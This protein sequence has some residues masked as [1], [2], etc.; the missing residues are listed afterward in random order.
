M[1]TSDV[2]GAID[3]AAVPYLPYERPHTQITISRILPSPIIS[4]ITSSVSSAFSHHG[5][6]AKLVEIMQNVVLFAQSIK[7]ASHSALRFDPQEF[8]DDMYWIEYQLLTFP[9]LAS[10]ESEPSISKA[11]RMGALLFMK[12]ILQEF[13]HSTTG[14]EILL[15]EL[16][17]ALSAVEEDEDDHNRQ[18][19][20][21]LCAIGALLAKRMTREWFVGR[22][23]LA[24]GLRAREGEVV[25][26]QLWRLLDLGEVIGEREVL[27]L[28]DEV[29]RLQLQ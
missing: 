7:Y 25:G 23:A 9:N 4:T 19:L 24:G 13:P 29:R 16:R 6:H 20:L 12:S 26:G 15:R 11:T 28:W 18:W 27:L 21:W 5:I 17:D 1:P 22:L 10:Q 14:P 3:Y 2:T 8:S